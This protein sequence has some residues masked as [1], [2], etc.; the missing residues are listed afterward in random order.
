[1]P[2]EPVLQGEKLAFGN[3][4]AKLFFSEAWH[5]NLAQHGHL[6]G[7]NILIRSLAVEGYPQRYG[8]THPDVFLAGASP[9][10][11]NK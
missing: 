7:T 6:Q 5:A 3:V 8:L 9:I 2:A 10:F 4:D 1:M 11:S